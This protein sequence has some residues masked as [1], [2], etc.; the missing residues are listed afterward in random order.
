MNNYNKHHIRNLKLKGPSR[1]Q[2][3]MQ[4]N[5][6]DSLLPQDHKARTVW[7]FVEKMDTT[8]C[9]A[10][11]KS[12]YNHAG[13]AATSPKVLFALW[14]Y[15]II[16][17]N[18]SARKLEELCNNHNAYKW[19]AGGVPVNRTMLAEF[20]TY[21]PMLF[22][23]LLTNCL[24]V[25]VQAGLIKD[26]DFAQDGTRIKANAGLSSYHRDGTLEKLREELKD[27][28]KQ[29][30]TEEVA[31]AY[32]KREKAKNERLAK[33]RLDR[34]EEAL[35]ILKREQNTKEEN[36]KKIRQPP[37]D[38]DLKEVRASITDADAR[39]MKMGDGGFRL[40]YNL[41]LAT[42]LDSRVIFGADVVSTLDPGTSPRMMLRVHNRLE[43]LHMNPPMNWI[44]DAAYSGKD[45]IE[46]VGE[47]FP[48]CRYYAPAKPRK[49]IDPKKHL[50]TDSEAVRNWRNQLGEEE[51]ENIY[52]KRC[53]TAEFSNAQMKNCGLR[54]FLVRGLIKV[55]SS[56][57][58]HCI[59]QN[60]M[61]Y[62]D[63]IKMRYAE[64]L[65]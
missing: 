26:T 52:S 56:A 61:R 25:M 2:M 20:R 23:D 30:Q 10:N 44:A 21:D 43:K 46:M 50:K 15:S 16:D 22:E 4:I 41:Q 39:K 3:E 60:V 9:Y 57:I 28:L 18:I 7:E 53:S 55:K 54:E 65:V 5:C 36:G 58:L 13:R 11:I 8:P 24:A 33:E 34:V 63:L 27:Y 29:L 51:F 35:N 37:S 59:A 38:E 31:N 48:N 42:G 1:N 40:A 6:L 14:L 47:M 45:D 64:V 32:E 17:G 49:G 62:M 12:Y 19:L